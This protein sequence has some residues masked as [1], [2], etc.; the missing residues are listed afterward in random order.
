MCDACGR[1]LSTE[2]GDRCRL[3][4]TADA[5]ALALGVAVALRENVLW[6][7]DEVA[8]R[9]PLRPAGRKKGERR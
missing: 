4:L 3:C 9:G 2:E 6:R 1:R 8:G 5:L 7:L